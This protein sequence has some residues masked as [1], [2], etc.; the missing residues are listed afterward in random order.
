MWGLVCVPECNESFLQKKSALLV[1]VSHSELNACEN[2]GMFLAPAGPRREGHPYPSG[3][4]PPKPDRSPQKKKYNIN[5]LLTARKKI[6]FVSLFFSSF[7]C[8][9]HDYKGVGSLGKTV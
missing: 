1:P 9:R 4:P 3:T 7:F 2:K 6:V 8:P 5:L